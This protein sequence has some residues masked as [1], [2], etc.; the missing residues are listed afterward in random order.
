MADKQLGVKILD[1]KRVLSRIF[2]KIKQFTISLLW[3]LNNIDKNCCSIFIK[4]G[5]AVFQ[6]M[7]GRKSILYNHHFL[8][9]NNLTCTPPLANAFST[10]S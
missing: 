8:N 4:N 7:I 1:K 10:S 3:V 5:Y 9:L 2:S 6:G